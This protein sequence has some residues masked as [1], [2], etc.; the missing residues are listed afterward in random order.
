MTALDLQNDGESLRDDLTHGLF[1]TH[2]F[3][4]FGSSS[5]STGPAEAKSNDNLDTEE[6]GAVAV[7]KVEHAP[8]EDDDGDLLSGEPG[9]APESALYHAMIKH[10]ADCGCRTNWSEK[11]QRT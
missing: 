4:E 9:H 8:L 6:W 5:S 11:S 3:A 7:K 10:H 1:R 2:K